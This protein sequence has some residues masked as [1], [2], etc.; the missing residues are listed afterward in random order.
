MKKSTT[1]DLFET[2][3]ETETTSLTGVPDEHT[4][5][6]SVPET[7]DPGAQKRRTR[8]PRT[9]RPAKAEPWYLMAAFFLPLV[10][11]Y[12]IYV[13]M[14]V[15]PFGKNSVLVLDLNGQYVYY[16]EYFREIIHGDASL[17][18]SWTRSLGGEFMGIFAYYLC[19]PFTLLVAFFPK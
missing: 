5:A 6:Q 4:R 16:F 12:L 7:E 15:W 11:M 18:Y 2:E 19:S 3:Q 8:R 17:L 14:E 13:G 9:A 10:L 1:S